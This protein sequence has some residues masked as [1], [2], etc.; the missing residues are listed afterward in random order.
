[1]FRFLSIICDGVAA[2]CAILSPVAIL[3]WLLKIT[4]LPATSSLVMALNSV[5]NP[6]DTMLASW[7]HTPP[8]MVNAQPVSTTQ[9]LL[10]LGFTLGFFSLH[11]A[12]EMLKSSE[13]RLDVRRQTRQQQQRLTQLH[14][15]EHREQTRLA[16][17]DWRI[18][19]YIQY[20]ASACPSGAALLEQAAARHQ[21]QSLV[22]EAGAI[23]LEFS[24][25]ESALKASQEIARGILNHYETLRPVDSQPP[26]IIGLHA[27]E[28]IAPVSVALQETARITGFGGQNQVVFSEALKRLLDARQSTAAGPSRSLGLY[29]LNEGRQ[30]EIFRLEL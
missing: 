17:L 9:A 7:I 19:A 1:M 16:A 15:K 6:L 25:M 18:Y 14:R 28:K 13:Q 11:S 22:R 24:E 23:A 30:A 26:F 2:I 21:A 20:D 4:A 29:V 5:F 3:H 12:A 8:L 27:V 10:A